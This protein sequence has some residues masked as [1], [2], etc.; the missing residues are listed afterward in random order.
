MKDE[1]SDKLDLAADLI[2]RARW[3]IALTGAG[4]SVD[5]GIPDFRSPGGLWTRYDPFEY[6]HI[7][8]FFRNPEKVWQMLKELSDLVVNAR[9]NPGHE[10]LAALERMGRLKAV[11]T[12]NVDNLHQEAGNTEVIE[13]HG[14]GNYLVCTQCDFR[15]SAREAETRAR[16]DGVFPPRCPQDQSVLKPDVIFFGESIPIRPL[17]ASEEHAGRS[18]LILVIGTSATVSPASSIPLITKQVGGKIIEINLTTT[19]LTPMAD[20]TLLG[21]ASRIMPL[22]VERVRALLEG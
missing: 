14:N 22:L 8:A 13:F 3:P 12:Q 4:I 7:E 18:D 15:T 17:A 11:I 2:V 6:A 16:Q 19:Q 1:F 21:S 10:G 9:P 5:S 20:L